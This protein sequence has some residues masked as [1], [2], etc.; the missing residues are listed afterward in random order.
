MIS[1]NMSFQGKDDLIRKSL[2][3]IDSLI[4]STSGF[5]Q[6]I[7]ETPMSLRTGAHTWRMKNLTCLDCHVRSDMG[8]EGCSIYGTKIPRYET[9]MSLRT[10]LIRGG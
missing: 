1:S 3:F 8:S 10:G 2:P 4:V 5:N 6:S 7:Y 9:P